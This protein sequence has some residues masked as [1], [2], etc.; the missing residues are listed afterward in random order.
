MY[1]LQF[2]GDE[3]VIR[4]SLVTTM[5][6]SECQV[7]FMAEKY[8]DDFAEICWWDVE[9]FPVFGNGAASNDDAPFS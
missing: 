8:L 5:L 9:K 1:W 2:R 6:R 4:L 3:K 7:A